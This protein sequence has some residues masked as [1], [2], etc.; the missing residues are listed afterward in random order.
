VYQFGTSKSLSIAPSKPRSRIAVL[1]A[2]QLGPD[3]TGENARGALQKSGEN[4]GHIRQGLTRLYNQ[5]LGLRQRNRQS[6]GN[7]GLYLNTFALMVYN[8]HYRSAHFIE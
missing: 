4:T 3:K 8:Y 1:S 6:H 7:D 5:F 2:E